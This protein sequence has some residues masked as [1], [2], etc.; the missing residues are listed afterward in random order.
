MELDQ[1]RD[2]DLVIDRANFTFIEKQFVSQGDYKGRTLTVQVTDN[3]V[4]GE[5]PGLML[6]LNWHNEASG[7]ADLSAFSVLDKANSIYRI[8]YPQ[9][10]MTPGRVIASIQIIQDGKVTNLKQFELT[11]QNLAGQPVGIVEKAEF[12]ALVAV[13]ADS[14]RFRTDIDVLDAIKAEKSDLN[15]TNQSVANLGMNKVD[16]DGAG[17]ISWA[18]ANQEFR[19]MVLGNTPPAVVG[20]DAVSTE[21][22]VNASVD[23]AKT[24]RL[25]QTGKFVSSQQIYIDFDKGE[26]KFPEGNFVSGKYRRVVSSQTLNDLDVAKAYAIYFSTTLISFYVIELETIGTIEQTSMFFGFVQ[27]PQ[28]TGF[29][30]GNFTGNKV[31]NTLL[32]YNFQKVLIQSSNRDFAIKLNGA[33][34]VLSVPEC[35]VLMS[36]DNYAVAESEVSFSASE[37]GNTALYY[38]FFDASVSKFGVV[39]S[40]KLNRLN[41]YSSVVG[42]FQS[43]TY[44]YDFPARLIIDNRA[45]KRAEITQTN[46]PVLLPIEGD[47]NVSFINKNVTIPA[48]VLSYYYNTYLGSDS[49]TGGQDITISFPDDNSPVRILFFDTIK[50]EF[51]FLSSVN[52]AQTRADSLLIL[53][54]HTDTKKVFSPFNITIDAQEVINGKVYSYSRL[55]ERK[56]TSATVGIARVDVDTKANTVTTFEF[57]AKKDSEDDDSFEIRFYY[58]KNGNDVVLAYLKPDSTKWKP[59]KVKLN[60]PFVGVA[61]LICRGNGSIKNS[62]AKNQ[63]PHKTPSELRNILSLS[64]RGSSYNAPENTIESFVYSNA[65]GFVGNEFDLDLTKD[66]VLVLSHDATIDRCS[67][68]TGTIRNMTYAELLAYDFGYKWRDK[69]FKDVRIPTLDEA[70][71][72]HRKTN[73]I[74]Q[75]ELK[76]NCI[77]ST[78]AQSFIETL[79]RYQMKE[80]C[81]VNSSDYTML[82]MLSDI[83][84]T[85]AYSWIVLPSIYDINKIKALGPNGY[86]AIFG[87]DKTDFE[88]YEPYADL[89]IANGIKFT[90]SSNYLHVQQKIIEKGAFIAA[91]D[92]VNLNECYF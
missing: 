54:F 92:D 37:P 11:V 55:E 14:N 42:S 32:P 82:K 4:V 28:R 5:V 75:I 59:Y 22:I 88:T 65:M 64:H 57:M 46:S 36:N 27:F 17:Q 91:L 19:E 87:W 52:P 89:C 90:G 39:N 23:T 6:N 53:V 8:E 49:I 60:T 62:L 72:F 12:S 44:F 67:N 24:T 10:M 61:K 48:R 26:I 86:C 58:D 80:K 50:K 31:S 41:G 1:F 77:N 18:M 45:V 73:Q 43:Q 33:E 81:F 3:G 2:V 25:V 47:I 56:N 70:L 69:G 20:I 66:G 63:T 84:N 78:N 38:I 76:N 85:I 15:A 29:L 68:G 40:T 74:C 79:E 13:L 30:N 34:S 7:L 35:A 16:K 9:H 71:D 21:N 83:D 51:Y